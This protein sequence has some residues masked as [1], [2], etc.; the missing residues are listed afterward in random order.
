MDV[1]SEETLVSR[2]Q[3]GISLDVSVADA[4]GASTRL[5]IRKRVLKSFVFSCAFALFGWYYPRYLIANETTIATKVPPYQ[6][7][8][9]GDVI[10]D[11]TLNDKAADP[12]M[13]P[14]DVLVHTALTLPFLVTLTH[15]YL[16]ARRSTRWIEVVTA[17]SAFLMTVGL[18][19]GTTQ[20]LKLVIQRRRPSFYDLCGFDVAT[21]KCTASL[22]KIREANFS[23]PSGHSSLTNC[24]M[25]FL[26]WYLGGKLA[27]NSVSSSRNFFLIACLCWGWSIFV[28]TSRLV[29]HWHHYADVLAGLVL[30]FSTGTLVYHTW[31]PPVWSSNA[32]I[33]RVMMPELESK[34]PTFSD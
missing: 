5:S 22:D 8:A 25:T 13:I 24:T 15:S 34:L 16:T 31:Y 20:I 19:E 28:A 10:L 30:G 11:F 29:D 9:A 4:L 2:L 14:S 27:K 33:A 26:V 18:S 23:F 3:R 12:P 32:G 6:V 21:L 7:T 1:A 17:V